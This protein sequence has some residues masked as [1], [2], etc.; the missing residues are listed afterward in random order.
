MDRYIYSE[1]LSVT[2]INMVSRFHR[3]LEEHPDNNGEEKE[4]IYLQKISI[5]LM[6][7]IH[8]VLTSCAFGVI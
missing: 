4:L 2:I 3:Y 1:G 6:N 8:Y 7:C 5:K